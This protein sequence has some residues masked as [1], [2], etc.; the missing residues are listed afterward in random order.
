MKGSSL[1]KMKQ[2][3]VTKHIA[4]YTYVDFWKHYSQQLYILNIVC[5]LGKNLTCTLRIIEVAHY[6]VAHC[7]LR[8]LRISW[9]LNNSES[10]NWKHRHK[11]GFLSRSWNDIHCLPYL[12]ESNSAY[13]H[14]KPTES[15]RVPCYCTSSTTFPFS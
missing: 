7:T 6:L 12:E 4:K 3:H 8:L 13:N 9:L 10:P 2:F 1:L 5:I 15:R 11:W 14:A